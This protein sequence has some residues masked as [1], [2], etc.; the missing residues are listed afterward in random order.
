ML[1]AI[2]YLKN[3][4][5]DYAYYDFTLNPDG[6]EEEWVMLTPLHVKG[7]VVY[8][9]NGFL[10]SGQLSARVQIP[11]SRCLTPVVQ[12]LSVDYDE[13]FEEQEFP[14]E[15][16]EIDLGDMAVQ[17]WLTSIPMQI[18]CDDQCKG[19]CPQCGKNLNEGGCA[20]EGVDL[21]PR[22]EILRVWASSSDD[23]EKR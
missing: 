22:L 21:D 3:D 11:C 18:L 6:L 19:L 8:G 12:A 17:L 4:P 20:C 13:E 16:A 5:G 15:D 2:G 7:S 1:F 23:S 10:L 9:G 14:E